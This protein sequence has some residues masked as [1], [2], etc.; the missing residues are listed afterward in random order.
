MLM[1][2]YIFILSGLLISISIL[3]QKNEV[4]ML[5]KS[6]SQFSVDETVKRIEANLKEKEIQVFALFDHGQNAKDSGMELLP[7]QVIVFGSPKVGT[8]LML[9]NPEV[10]H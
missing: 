7:N 5:V 4:N 6:K 10:I 1:K 3:A 9:Q 8:L 2:R